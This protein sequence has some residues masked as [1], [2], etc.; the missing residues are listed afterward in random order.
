MTH[1]QQRIQEKT[2]RKQSDS[3]IKIQVE[4]GI[5]KGYSQ[6]KLKEI[7]SGVKMRGLRQRLTKK[8]NNVFNKPE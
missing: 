4:E 2:Q 6:E 1:K 3:I 5:K 7:I 8:I